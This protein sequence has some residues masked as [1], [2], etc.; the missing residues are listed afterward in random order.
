MRKV[1][2]KPIPYE[3]VGRRA[4]DVAI[5][6]S[7]CSKAL[8]GD[9]SLKLFLIF[10]DLGWKAVRGL[11]EMCEDLWRWQTLNPEGFKHN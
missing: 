9:D 11:Q 6:F 7:D 3:I 2:G 8:K 5:C 1:S 4:G 10:A